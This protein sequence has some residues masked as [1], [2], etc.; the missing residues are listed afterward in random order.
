MVGKRAFLLFG[1][2]HYGAAGSRVEVW[3]VD[4]PAAG[5]AEDASEERTGQWGE[6]QQ[7]RR[8]VRAGG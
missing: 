1:S 7:G 3:C 4:G 2:S 8:K 5:G 6:E